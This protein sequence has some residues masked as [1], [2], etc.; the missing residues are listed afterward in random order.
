MMKYRVLLKKNLLVSSVFR[1]P[2][3]IKWTG[4]RKLEANQKLSRNIKSES[5]AIHGAPAQDKYAM[6]VRFN[7]VSVNY[8]QNWKRFEDDAFAFV[9]PD[10]IGYIMN[11]VC[12]VD[13]NI[14]LTFEMEEENK[15][16][17][18]DVMVIGN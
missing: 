9:L 4:T 2:M 7:D 17:F 12:S 18:L 8:L 1:G 15:P 5:K 14:Q 6:A 13:K 11:Q 10:K 3:Y 16:A